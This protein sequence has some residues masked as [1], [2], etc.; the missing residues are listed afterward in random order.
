MLTLLAQASPTP[1]SRT[2]MTYHIWG[3]DPPE[4]DALKSHIY[5]LRQALDKPFDT[6]ML[7]TITNLGYQ[8][9]AENE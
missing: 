6:P 2:A 1:V 7:T 4:T 9:A 3:D 5:S 8:L